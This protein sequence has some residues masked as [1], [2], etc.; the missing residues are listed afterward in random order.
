MSSQE[1]KCEACGGALDEEGWC[2]PCK[3]RYILIYEGIEVLNAL[4]IKERDSVYDQ[5]AKR[6]TSLIN[7]S[8]IN[9][10]HY[11]GTHLSDGEDVHWIQED[12]RTQ[13]ADGTWVDIPG[14]DFPLRSKRKPKKTRKISE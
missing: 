10:H 7:R 6:I 14:E 12:Q 2:R 13:L 4:S 1:L 11:Q 8:E 3:R 5:G 9:G